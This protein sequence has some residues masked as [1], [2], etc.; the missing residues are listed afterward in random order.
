MT[1]VKTWISLEEAAPQFGMSFEGM[2]NA[3]LLGRFPVPTFKLGRR[4]V[5]DRDVLAAFFAERKEEGLS[6]LR[7]LKPPKE[8]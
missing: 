5:I 4:R 2:K 6:T 3:V 1:D 7:A 8:D